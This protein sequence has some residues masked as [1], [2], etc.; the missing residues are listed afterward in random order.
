MQYKNLLIVMLY[1]LETFM[2][3]LSVLHC[4]LTNKKGEKEYK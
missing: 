4:D 2:K 3:N 1:K